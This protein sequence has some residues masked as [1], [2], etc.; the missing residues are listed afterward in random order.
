MGRFIGGRNAREGGRDR[1]GDEVLWEEVGG[2]MG[3]SAAK[4]ARA[5]IDI[6]D[7]MTI[8]SRSRPALATRTSH[9][10]RLYM[11]ND[12]YGVHLGLRPTFPPSLCHT[13]HLT[14]KKATARTSTILTQQ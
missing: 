4:K 12:E 5:W 1:S 11:Y 10:A 2:V 8:V 13:P 7:L 9:L 6:L 3:A 14:G